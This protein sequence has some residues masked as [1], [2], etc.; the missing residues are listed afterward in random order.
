MK[1]RVMTAGSAKI[2]YLNH[3]SLTLGAVYWDYYP[4]GG[5][6]KLQF[7]CNNHN[8]LIPLTKI[9][10]ACRAL[11]GG[12]RT[13]ASMYWPP[14]PIYTYNSSRDCDLYHSYWYEEYP[15]LYAARKAYEL[16]CDG[17]EGP[18]SM[19]LVSEAEYRAHEGTVE[20]WDQAAEM[21]GY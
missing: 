21:M 16:R 1:A 4:E 19:C 3:K 20:H 14:G 12:A 7:F 15:S 11:R 2:A 6:T 17:A 9:V 18:Q 5:A 8:F 10:R 13:V